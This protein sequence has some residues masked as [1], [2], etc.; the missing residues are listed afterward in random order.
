MIGQKPHPFCIIFVYFHLYGVTVPHF[1]VKKKEDKSLLSKRKKL[2]SFLLEIVA[3]IF[4]VIF[5]NRL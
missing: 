4:P 5:I 1:S 2:F 3:A